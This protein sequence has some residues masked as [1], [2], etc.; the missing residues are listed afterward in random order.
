MIIAVRTS[1]VMIIDCN[2]ML[3]FRKSLCLKFCGCLYHVFNY[4]C[5]A[6]DLNN[7]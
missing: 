3:V 5:I 2:A 1:A 7:S 6:E 4:G